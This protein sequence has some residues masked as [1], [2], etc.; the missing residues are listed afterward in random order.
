VVAK[1]HVEQHFTSG[2]LVRDLIIGISDGLTVPFAIAAGLS[3]VAPTAGIIVAA[4]LA[5]IA[6]GAISMGLGGYL[7][8]KGEAEHYAREYYKEV[9]E[10]K[11][12]PLQE[13]QEVR[14]ILSQYKLT[15]EEIEPILNSFQRHPDNWVDFMMRFELGLEKPDPRQ[16]LFSAATISSAYIV[17]GLIPLSPYLIEPS[18]PTALVLSIAVTLTALFVFG[19]IKGQFTGKTPFRS[20]FQMLLIGGLSAT[21]AFLLARLATR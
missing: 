21:A 6:A 18:I 13:R 17:G 15:N 4:G 16:A 7:A 9:K 10:V 1:T 14:E 12:I 11:E 2:R 19:F 20:A 5:E 3:E 8:A